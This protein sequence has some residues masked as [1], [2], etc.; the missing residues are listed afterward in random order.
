MKESCLVKKKKS[1]FFFFSLEKKQFFLKS[2][3]LKI[4]LSF[5]PTGLP[6]I[7]QTQPCNGNSSL[8][9]QPVGSY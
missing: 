4:C 1:F 6:C 2:A 7:F 8:G 9:F 3:T 5:S